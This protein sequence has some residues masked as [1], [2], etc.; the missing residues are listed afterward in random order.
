MQ[1]CTHSAAGGTIQRLKPIPAIVRLRLSM[2]NEAPVPPGAVVELMEGLPKRLLIFDS[3]R[4]SWIELFLPRFAELFNRLA[5]RR[6]KLHISQMLSD[7][8]PH[9][10]I[11]EFLQMVGDRGHRLVV[12][13]VR[14]E[15]A[16]LIG[17]VGKLLRRHS[18]PVA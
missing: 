13:L 14:K 11:P 3:P 10:R 15:L 1:R 2:P 16:N 5:D 17:H 4:G 8:T 7:G 6:I 12:R 9:P 18:G